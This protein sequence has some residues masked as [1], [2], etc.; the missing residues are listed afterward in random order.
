MVRKITLDS[1]VQS[2]GRQGTKK[3]AEGQNVKCEEHL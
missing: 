2:K 3:E 1:I